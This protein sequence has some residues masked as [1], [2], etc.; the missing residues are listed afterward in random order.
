MGYL[1]HFTNVNNLADSTRGNRL[2]L[3]E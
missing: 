3:G 2:I 1:D